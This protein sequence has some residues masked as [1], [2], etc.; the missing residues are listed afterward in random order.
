M[1]NS[2]L[3]QTGILYCTKVTFQSVLLSSDVT[4]VKWI[5]KE[6][7]SDSIPPEEAAN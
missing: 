2:K 5:C 3:H 6:S 7:N 1:S 4:Q